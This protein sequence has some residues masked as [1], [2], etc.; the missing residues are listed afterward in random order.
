MVSSKSLLTLPSFFPASFSSCEHIL[1][2]SF[3]VGYSMAVYSFQNFIHVFQYPGVRAVGG[4]QYL[5]L[6]HGTLASFTLMG[7]IEVS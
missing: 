7:T 2:L 6:T 4:K 1:R 3:P 5:S